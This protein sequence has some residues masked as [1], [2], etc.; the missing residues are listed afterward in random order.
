MD[1]REELIAYIEELEKENKKL[2]RRTVRLER[3]VIMLSSLN[4][5]ALYLRDYNEEERSRSIIELAEAKEKAEHA[6]KAKSNFLRSMSHEIRTPMNAIM[7]MDE[8]ILKESREEETLKYA[9]D[10]KTA[11]ETLL[12][13]INGILD[14]SKIESGKMEITDSEYELKDVVNHVLNM[15]RSKAF[16][17]GLKY[18]VEVDDDTPAMFYGDELRL[19]Q[20]MINLI[21]NAIKY[22][23]Y[24]SVEVLISYDPQGGF[25]KIEV[26]DTGIGIRKEDAERLFKSFSRLKDSVERQ[27]EGTGLGLNITKELAMLMGGD[28]TFESEYGKGSIFRA[29]VKH[30]ALGDLKY[31]AARDLVP[32]PGPGDTEILFS[33]P[34]VRVLVVD[35]N[36]MN[37]DVIGA[38]LKPT[39]IRVKEAASGMECIERLKKSGFDL[40]L[41]DQMMPGL[42][43]DETLRMIREEHIADDTPIIALTADAVIGAREEYLKL[44]FA[45]YLSKP[46]AYKDLE[47]ILMKHLPS[48]LYT[49]TEVKK[50][51][52][53][54]PKVLVVAPT[55]EE[56][57]AIRHI[58]GTNADGVFV[59]DEEKAEKYLSKHSVDYIVRRGDGK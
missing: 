6:N 54:K 20:I 53:T 33:A 35:D 49:L 46:V 52:E 44:G 55:T 58:M 4:D 26:K 36:D 38:L 17:K 22:T 5:C 12:S 31:K 9:S 48:E 18:N 43:G 40:V 41:L 23:E 19:R 42:N 13:I 1:N 8:M 15:T 57:D 10:I 21:N 7:G 16:E 34:A 24:G 51:E 32:E 30:K 59:K 14:L 37:L 39:G 25:L 50:K 47:T 27:I 56:L 3:D 45:D 28:V 11:G 2:R 29:Y